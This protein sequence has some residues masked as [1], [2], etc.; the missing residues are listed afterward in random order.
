LLPLLGIP[1][2]VWAGLLFIL[3]P[4]AVFALLL[5]LE[6]VRP[7]ARKTVKLGDLTVELWVRERKQPVLAG[8]IVVPVAPDMRMVAGIAKVVRDATANAVQ[9]EA[10][11]VAPL[12]PG[13]GFAGSGGR[14]RFDVAALAVVMDNF[15]RTTPQWI[16]EG[17]L[18]AMR[19][20]REKGATTCLLPD[21]TEDLLQQPRWITDE[22]RR[23]TCAPI[24]RAMMDAVLNSGETMDVIKIWVWR[25]V[26]EDIFLKEMERLEQ[27]GESA[28]TSGSLAPHTS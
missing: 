22:Q 21:M 4:C 16:T 9:Y 6:L 1:F 27:I 25:K 3:L 13:E 7:R 5:L 19:K 12:S 14:Y 2:V 20:A 8:A 24:A 28:R 26:N 17:I 18:E 15:K 10:L 23:T 11:Q